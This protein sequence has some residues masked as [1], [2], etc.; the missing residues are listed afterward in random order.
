MLFDL[1]VI[2]AKLRWEPNLKSSRFEVPPTRL[3]NN[4]PLVEVPS[5]ILFVSSNR[6]T[7]IGS[8][9]WIAWILIKKLLNT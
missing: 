7:G 4:E 1:D 3:F 2:A 5:S 9:D 6:L 8:F